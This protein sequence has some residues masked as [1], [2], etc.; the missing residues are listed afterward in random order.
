[1][2]LIKYTK[3]SME[4]KS[5]L[6]NSDQCGCFYCQKIYHPS[7]IKEWCDE[8]KTAICPH[9]GIDSVLPDIGP[10]NISSKLLKEL[11]EFYFKNGIKK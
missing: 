7:E 1:M 5:L 9:C 6:E 4:N 3:F 10:V 11:N 8:G 2:D